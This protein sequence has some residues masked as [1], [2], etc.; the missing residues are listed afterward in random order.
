MQPLLVD[1]NKRIWSASNLS[2]RSRR[3]G[4]FSLQLQTRSHVREGHLDMVNVWP[5]RSWRRPLTIISPCSARFSAFSLGIKLRYLELG[6]SELGDSSCFWFEIGIAMCGSVWG[7]M[8]IKERYFPLQSGYPPFKF[9]FNG[10]LW[11]ELISCFPSI[12]LCPILGH[13]LSMS[14]GTLWRSQFRDFRCGFHNP[15]FLPDFGS[16]S[17]CCIICIKIFVLTL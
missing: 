6:S 10:D 16:D 8:E 12:E 4:D 11:H 15:I 13:K 7:S 1:L 5:L 2:L 14:F 3:R 17:N 9:L